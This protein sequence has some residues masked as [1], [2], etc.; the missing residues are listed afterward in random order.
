MTATPAGLGDLVPDL[1]GER[2]L[3]G[4]PERGLLVLGHLA[5]RDVDGGGAVLDERARDLDGVVVGV[6]VGHPVGRGDAHRH[7]DRAGHRRADGVEDLE[8]EAQPVL[9][10]SAVARRCAGWR[11]ARG[12]RRAGSR[13]RRAARPGR[14]RPSTPALGG[15]DEVGDHLVQVGAGRLARQMAVLAVGQRRR[16]DDLPVVRRRAAR[17]CPPTSAWSSPCARSGRAGGR[18]WPWCAAWTKSTTRFQ[19]S[20]CSS[21]HS[22]GQPGGD[23]ALRRDADHLRHHQAGAAE[24]LRAEVDE[25]E[26]VG[27]AVDGASTCPSARRS[28]RFFSSSAPMPDRLEHRRRHVGRA[29]VAGELGLHPRGEVA[30]AVLEVLEGDPARAGEQ[31]EDELGGVLVGVHADVLE[32]LE[33]GLGGALGRLHDGLALGLVRRQRGLARSAARAGRRPARARPPSPAWCPS[34]SRS[35]RCA[36]RR[37]AARRCR[38]TSARCGRW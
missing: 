24:G 31:V 32:P 14:S 35:A 15:G 12:T 10:R 11:S 34:R 4:P 28:T 29:L 7:R 22:P 33:R 6:A 3:V 19:A 36:R 21:F 20:R 17:P 16:A 30:V 37:R 23:P 13:G 2:G 9:Q 27:H 8:R 25:V 38:R 26:L 1:V 5:G 18:S